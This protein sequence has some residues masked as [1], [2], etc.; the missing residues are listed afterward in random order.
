MTP[1]PL[2]AGITQ[3]TDFLRNLGAQSPVAVALSG[4][5]DSRFLLHMAQRAGIKL[6]AVH[7]QGPHIPA[8]ESTWAH[9]WAKARGIPVLTLDIS[10]LAIEG[11]RDNSPERC[12]YCKKFL[13]RAMRAALKERP[14]TGEWCLC[15]GTNADDCHAHRPGLKALQEEAIRSPLAECGVDKAHIRHWA[16]LTGLEDPQQAARP[17]LLTRL[18][19]GMQP[20]PALL[21]S[22]ARTEADLLQAGLTDFR[23]RL[24]PEPLL[25]S[26]PLNPE[27]RARAQAVL[28]KHGFTNTEI[29]EETTLSGFFDRS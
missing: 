24:R 9:S 4:G 6:C 1:A 27:L 14:T 16:A 3:L 18:A 28:A 21:D 22:L 5:L 26:T 17:C 15:D 12:Y 23:M 11:V 7:A 2:P 19:Y 25:Q 20:T 13:L 29:V 10:P 8:A